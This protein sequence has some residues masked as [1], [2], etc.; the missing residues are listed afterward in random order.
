[1]RS[2]MLLRWRPSIPVIM[3]PTFWVLEELFW[4]NPCTSALSA[5]LR[6]SIEA[7]TTP[8]K[9]LG[10]LALYA[11]SGIIVLP[12]IPTDDYNSQSWLL[13]ELF[14]VLNIPLK[15]SGSEAFIALF[16]Y[17]NIPT[18][19]SIVTRVKSYDF[20][21]FSFLGHCNWYVLDSYILQIPPKNH[22]MFRMSFVENR[23]IWIPNWL[24]SYLI[25]V[26]WKFRSSYLIIFKY[27]IWRGLVQEMKIAI[28]EC[29]T[30]EWQ[31][32]DTVKG[33]PC[34]LHTDGTTTEMHAVDNHGGQANLACHS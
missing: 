34:T 22:S 32:R 33:F 30:R 1:M 25:I 27:L 17:L 3:S 14:Q 19:D 28:C 16:F 2:S 12:A 9:F 5:G 31:R 18:V 7:T 24:Y 8:L 10:K 29:C 6:P 26:I 15:I 11:I 21:F 20:F 13:L 23:I 4:F